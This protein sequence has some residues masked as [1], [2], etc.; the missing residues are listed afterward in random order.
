MSEQNEPNDVIPAG[1][2]HALL[3][4]M[5]NFIQ[6]ALEAA[7][8][9]FWLE[10]GSLLGCMRDKCII[11][12][13]DDI[14]LAVESRDYTKALNALRAMC[15]AGC[16]LKTETSDGKITEY[17]VHFES[18][19][20]MLKVFIPG[21]WAE[22]KEKGEIIGT[23]TIDVFSYT[24]ANDVLKLT[25]IAQRKQFPN[26]YYK[27]SE[28][29]PLIKRQFGEMQFYTPNEPMGYLN[30]YYGND[31]MFVIKKDKRDVNNP[32]NKERGTI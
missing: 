19:P 4:G 21:L 5:L 30:R 6:A 17:K 8:V 2:H 23:P 28:L 16:F 24:R 12:H 26:C 3:Y 7:K 11:P 25:H 15:N 20:H 14:D 29:Y 9:N 22:N 1:L 18:L 32:M 31:C 27:K 10:G 13:D